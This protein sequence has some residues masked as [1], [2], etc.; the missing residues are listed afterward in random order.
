MIRHDRK[1]WVAAVALSAL[2]GFVDALGFLKLGGFFVSFMSG[3][4]TRLGVGLAERSENAAVGA[5][6]VTGFVSGVILASLAGHFVQRGRPVIVLAMVSALL[7]GAAIAHDLGASLIAISL[8]TVAMGA[9]NVVFQRS[10]EVSIGLTYMTGTLV[11]FG[12]HV[13]AALVGSAPW[14]WLPYLLLW[15]GLVAGAVVG[16]I[17]YRLVGLDGLWIAAGL[18]AGLAWIAASRSRMLST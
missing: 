5:G 1:A 17:V 9:E 2:A 4:S 7:G 8:I 12:Q 10:G 11:K 3:N 13:S 16:A 6:L 18:A 14:L 15:L